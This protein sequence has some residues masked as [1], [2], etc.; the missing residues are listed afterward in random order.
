[1]NVKPTCAAKKNKNRR[2]KP[3]AVFVYRRSHAGRMVQRKTIADDIKRRT[4]F[5]ID[6]AFSLAAA[7]NDKRRGIK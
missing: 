3:P 5:V 4:S 2:R 7:K 6:K 1:V